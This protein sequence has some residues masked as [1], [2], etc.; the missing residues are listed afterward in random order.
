MT[1]EYIDCPVCIKDAYVERFRE[2]LH[3]QWKD[4]TAEGR[5]CKY[6]QNREAEYVLEVILGLSHEE[7]ERIVGEEL[8]KEWAEERSN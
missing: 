4:P 7:I 6:Y 1:H 8:K 3:R 2:L 5:M